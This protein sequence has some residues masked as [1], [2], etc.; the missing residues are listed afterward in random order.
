MLRAPLRPLKKDDKGP[1]VR[2]LYAY[3]RQLGYATHAP[4]DLDRYD[5]PLAD[6]V[7][8]YQEFFALRTDGEVGEQTLA[9]MRRPR[10]GMPDL[11]PGAA[12]VPRAVPTVR[13]WPRTDLT[14]GFIRLT[15]DLPP[16]QVTSAISQGFATWAAVTPLTFKRVPPS[17]AVS[18][19][20]QALA[21]SVRL[22]PAFDRVQAQ[23]VQALARLY[24]ADILI[25]FLVRDHGDPPSLLGSPPF[26]DNPLV[27]GHA[28]PPPAAM[29]PELFAGDVHFNEA[30]KWTNRPGLLTDLQAAAVHEIGHALGLGHTTTDAD[31][32]MTP[33]GAATRQLSTVDIEAIQSLY[34][35]AP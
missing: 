22:G 18:G 20:L 30:P 21:L 11:L 16:A 5:E 1:E 33:F 19:A 31:S 7:R 8:R 28:W 29:A 35:A 25:G 34:G 15:S 12:A 24:R 23:A 6:S 10:C 9:Q 32:V 27:L 3:L 13:A 26:N 2:A 17:F 14:Y 4:R